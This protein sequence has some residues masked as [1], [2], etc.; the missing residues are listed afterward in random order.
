[1]PNKT[2]KPQPIVTFRIERA[3]PTPAQRQAW[4][5]LFTRLI[6]ECRRELK[7]ESEAK[8]ER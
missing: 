5:Q 3:K 8:R 4:F 7:D 1:M 6:S 2:Q